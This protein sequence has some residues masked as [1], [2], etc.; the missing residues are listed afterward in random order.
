MAVFQIVECWEG[1]WQGEGG[2]EGEWQ[3]RGTADR[4]IAI[5]PSFPCLGTTCQYLV[6]KLHFSL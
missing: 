6:H 4:L 2:R 1:E 3:G 5:A